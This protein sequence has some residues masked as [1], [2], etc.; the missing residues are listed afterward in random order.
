M[1]REIQRINDAEIKSVSKTSWHDQYKHSAY[2]FVG[3]KYKFVL[4]FRRPEL[5][6]DGRR[7]H[8]CLLTVRARLFLCLWCVCIS[9]HCCSYL[10]YGEVVD[11]NLVRDKV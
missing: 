8:N 9:V 10:R 6:N 2:I 11:I 3:E 4:N 1:V 5:W 7:H